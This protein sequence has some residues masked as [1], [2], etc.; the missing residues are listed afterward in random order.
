V[1]P[2]R[3]NGF[4]AGLEE[5]GIA[6]E[7]VADGNA[8]Y[9]TELGLQVTEDLLVAHPE[10]EVIFAN[11]DSMALGAQA[12]LQSAGRDDVL[13]VGID[14]QKE[15][16][17]EIDA[18]GCDGQYVSTGLNSPV[19]AAQQSVEILL[20]VISGETSASDYEDVIFTPAVGI[21]C[22]NIDEYYDPLSIF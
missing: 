5:G 19:L 11:N 15:A 7:L 6:Y 4:L 1:G 20:S 14:G 10:I 12:A 22:N 21:D 8:E 9:T 2:D 3:Y 18:G 16:F 13:L 17:A